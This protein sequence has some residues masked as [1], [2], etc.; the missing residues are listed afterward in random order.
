MMGTWPILTSANCF[1]WVCLDAFLPPE[2]WRQ[3]I[4][5]QILTLSLQQAFILIKLGVFFFFFWST[6]SLWSNAPAI[7]LHLNFQLKGKDI[8]AQDWT[9]AGSYCV[10][11]AQLHGTAQDCHR[12]ELPANAAVREELPWL[13]GTFSL[14]FILFLENLIQLVSLH[15][16]ASQTPQCCGTRMI[17]V[18]NHV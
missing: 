6:F 2:A 16:T 8:T 10:I 7:Q 5:F 1:V 14:G 17:N 15:L 9:E 4:F 3:Y 11:T 13:F 18:Y 12:D